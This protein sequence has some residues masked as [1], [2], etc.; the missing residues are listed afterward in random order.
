[1]IR[2]RNSPVRCAASASPWRGSERGSLPALYTM[3]NGERKGQGRLRGPAS[4]EP[5]GDRGSTAGGRNGGRRPAYN[6]DQRTASAVTSA[7][8]GADP[9]KSRTSSVTT[10]TNPAADV[11]PTP[12]STPCKRASV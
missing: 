3:A 12:R 1:S 4:E 2:R 8:C 7:A 5:V 6:G 9:A 10:R 11:L